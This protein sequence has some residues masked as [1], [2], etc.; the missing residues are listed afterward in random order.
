MAFTFRTAPI[1]KDDPLIKSWPKNRRL[2]SRLPAA[3]AV[4]GTFYT[5]IPSRPDE[6]FTIVNLR[7]GPFHV[8][9]FSA[10]ETVCLNPNVALAAE[11]SARR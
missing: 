10:R 1:E 6:C 3:A 4:F 2:C 5:S 9:F 11:M 8:F 7:L